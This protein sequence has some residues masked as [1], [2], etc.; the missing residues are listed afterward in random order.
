MYN[1][2][3]SS[4]F[5]SMRRSSFVSLLGASALLL[6]PVLS[7]AATLTNGMPASDAL[8]Q[9]DD[10]LTNPQPIYTKSAA[11]N[12]PNR[13][14]FNFSNIVGG[15]ALDSVHH[16]LFVADYGN[17]RVLIYTLGSDNSFI[18][19]VP[20]Y[21]LGQSNFY[22]NA[23]ATTQSG[24]RLPIGLAYD[25]TTDRLYVADSSNG[26]VL[27]FDLANIANGMSASY[28]LGQATFTA[29]DAATTQSTMRPVSSM[30]LT[31]DASTNRLFVAD[32]VNNRVL[33][34]SISTLS[35]GMNADYVL[36]QSTFTASGA[37]TT[38]TGMSGPR[39]VTVDSGTNHIFVADSSNRRVLVF[40]GSILANG[41]AAAKVLGE[42]TFTT[43]ANVGLP[44]RVNLWLPAGVAYDT[45]ANHLF[46]SDPGDA[47]VMVYSGSSLSNGMSGAYVLGQTNYTSYTAAA[48]QSGLSGN[49][50]HLFVDATN[51]R[52]YVVDA[53]YARVMF[54]NIS[55][56]SNG[57]AAS[58]ALGQYDDSLT[59]PQPVYTKSAANNGPNRLGMNDSSGGGSNLLSIDYNHHRLFVGDV[60]NNRVLVYNLDSSNRLLDHLPDYVLG[61]PNFYTNATGLS[62][63]TLNSP[64]GLAY[65]NVGDHLFVVDT[66]NHRVVV[67]SGATLST[68]MSGT[69]VIGQAN[70]TTA[71]AVTTQASLYGPRGA[72]IDEAG[73]RLFVASTS[74][75]RVTVYDIS[76]LSNGMSASHVI[77]QTLFT[78]SSANTTQSGL[79]NPY[80]AA[81]DPNTHYLYVAQFNVNRVT[82]FDV[83]SITDGKPASYVL[84][85]SDFTSS[86][87][88]VTQSGF[89]A[90]MAVALDASGRRLFVTQHSCHRISVFDVNNLSNGLPA[91][92]VLG[93]ADFNTNT[94][95]SI[96]QTGFYTPRSVFFDQTNQYLYT[97]ERNTNR[98]LLFDL[99]PDTVASLTSSQSADANTLT[100]TATVSP[101]DAGGT[102][103]FT[104][105]S[106]SL[107]SVAIVTGTATLNLPAFSYTAGTHSITA[108][109]GGSTSYA[110]SVSSAITP[111]IRSATTT[112]TPTTG[113]GG[114]GSHR[115][116]PAITTFSSATSQ[117]SSSSARS[118][119]SSISSLANSSRSSVQS[120]SVHSSTANSSYSSKSSLSSNSSIRFTT[121]NVHLRSLATIKSKAKTQ[122][123][124]NTPVTL[125]EVLTD[126][127]KVRL[128]NGKEGYVLRRYLRK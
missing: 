115:I 94:F 38:Q 71:A 96:S 84:G 26:R 82:V 48:T 8:G 79:S 100:L 122:L 46:V 85:Q 62:Q 128:S 61:Q 40:T 104:D 77:G 98:L 117:R 3:E 102:I 39:A 35:N 9:Y 53:G 112:T 31:L 4:L 91:M 55:S 64:Q 93:A 90:P 126:W 2:A 87:A 14:G 47:R 101:S 29:S 6:L 41:M 5:L 15:V 123:L 110:P 52:L 119:R 127:A 72:T 11:N 78:D 25:D 83:S 107:G 88:A 32:N 111:I 43:A 50:R 28:V 97:S 99:R 10:S 21:V 65:D 118:I 33:I 19:R 51:R 68:G 89:F 106:Q 36:G 73:R 59:N 67:F 22:S 92:N 121:V 58:D 34:F 80:T 30:G 70:F 113:G 44:N 12:G 125:L 75:N 95:G 86:V 57:M 60:D 24:M 54:Y 56:L 114:G 69:I 13:F 17:N 42:P 1:T 103:T 37:A 16:R 7:H 45:L 105:S 109:Y 108:S 49:P 20:D 81:Y 116:I 18:V 23:A 27:V 74:N 120:A 66:T 124:P 63:T 76:A